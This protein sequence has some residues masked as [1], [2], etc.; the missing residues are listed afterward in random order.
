MYWFSSSREG[1]AFR[2]P[3]VAK[4]KAE[5]DFCLFCFSPVGAS[6]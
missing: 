1:K 6:F 4:K 3:S 2:Q 5:S